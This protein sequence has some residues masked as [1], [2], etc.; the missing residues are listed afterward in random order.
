LAPDQPRIIGAAHRLADPKSVKGQV[1]RGF[2]NVHGG[3]I[4]SLEMIELATYDPYRR[5]AVFM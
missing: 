1:L 2:S 3:R 4:R 5:S